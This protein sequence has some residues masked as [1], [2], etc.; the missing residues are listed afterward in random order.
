[1]SPRF[2]SAFEDGLLTGDVDGVV[3]D[4]RADR[5]ADDARAGAARERFER[6][7]RER[8]ER[9]ST[10]LQDPETEEALRALGYFE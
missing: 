4:D 6:F 7:E 10:L 3:V 9:A 1:M 8:R 2:F 5:P